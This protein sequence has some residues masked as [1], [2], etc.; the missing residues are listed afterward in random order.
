MYGID[1]NMIFTNPNCPTGRDRHLYHF[2][3]AKSLMLILKPMSLKL[4]K[5]QNL[6]DLNETNPCCNWSDNGLS[7][8]KVRKYIE[9]HYKFSLIYFS[10]FNK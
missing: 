5:F 4:S 1:K 7:K 8:I 2:T 3:T 9:E 6:N 10:S